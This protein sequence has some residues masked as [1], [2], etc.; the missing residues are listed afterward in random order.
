MANLKVLDGDGNAKYLSANEAGSDGD[1][2]IPTHAVSGTVTVDATGQGDLPIT[3]D[4]EAVVLGA[5]TAAFG[6]LAANSGVDIGDVDVAS[7]A[8][9]SAVIHGQKAISTAGTEE[10][11]A[12]S[13]ALTSGVTVKAL[14]A[15]TGMVYVGAD[16]V[17]S[18]TGFVLDAG[19]S[20]FI[21]ID[22]LAS[23][24]IDVDTNAEGVSY[25]GS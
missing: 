8:I 14:H 24:F 21:E 10:A 3:L 7:V 22:D 23:V 2:F 13:T 16:P 5:G 11:L 17:T 6:K 20:V 1:P 15:N 12:S 18:S 25:I 9:P 19:E 4:G